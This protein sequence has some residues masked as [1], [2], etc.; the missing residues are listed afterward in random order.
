MAN[1]KSAEKRNRQ[2]QKR[3]A[4]NIN[5]RTTVKDAV[6]SLRETLTTK[7][8]GKT[9]DA[10]KAATRTINKAASKGVVHKR[11]ASRR[12]SRLAKAA[13]RAKAAA[14]AK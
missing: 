14:A 6:K 12:I 10:L 3:R 7:D 8:A 2:A 1:T 4:R 13:N 9:A 5:I 11:A